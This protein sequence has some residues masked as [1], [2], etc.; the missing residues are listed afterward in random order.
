[1]SNKTIFIGEYGVFCSLCDVVIALLDLVS[2]LAFDDGETST[3]RTRC[4]TKELL[5]RQQDATTTH[6]NNKNKNNNSSKRHKKDLHSVVVVESR[7]E[8]NVRDETSTLTTR[9]NLMTPTTTTVTLSNNKGSRMDKTFHRCCLEPQHT[10]I[11]NNDD[12]QRQHGDDDDHDDHDDHAGRLSMG[13]RSKESPPQPEEEPSETLVVDEQIPKQSQRQQQ[14]RHVHFAI[15]DH[16][17]QNNVSAKKSPIQI[18]PTSKGNRKLTMLLQ[19]DTLDEHR[20]EKSHGRM[21]TMRMIEHKNDVAK[22][23]SAPTSNYRKLQQQKAVV[24]VGKMMKDMITRPIIS[25]PASTLQ[26]QG[27]VVE[28][29]SLWQK[30]LRSAPDRLSQQ[31]ILQQLRRRRRR[32]NPTIT[33]LP[34][35]IRKG[36]NNNKNNNYY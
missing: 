31:L 8:T 28:R 20:Q 18:I 1:M 17:S 26:H 9:E 2:D 5:P 22:R 3:N 21:T 34:I 15:V 11:M 27:I 6:H 35:N 10:T 19:T 13:R 24:V 14:G 32:H 16:P 29:A 12:D 23:D 30:Q 33:S 36:W 4:E 7:T 25:R